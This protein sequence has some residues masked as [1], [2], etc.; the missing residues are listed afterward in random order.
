MHVLFR[1]KNH[2][3]DQSLKNRRLKRKKKDIRTQFSYKRKD[4]AFKGPSWRVTAFSVMHVNLSERTFCL[5]GISHF[6]PSSLLG[7]HGLGGP[8]ARHLVDK[9][10]SRASDA[11][12]RPTPLAPHRA[13][14]PQVYF[15]SKWLNG[16]IPMYGGMMLNKID[17]LDHLMCNPRWWTNTCQHSYSSSRIPVVKPR[18]Y[19]FVLLCRKKKTNSNYE[20]GHAYVQFYS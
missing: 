14:P 3:R 15:V 8:P 9:M 7:R 11:P 6:L 19:K 16:R 2:I 17:Q 20:S 12:S 18:S 1:K 10:P 5:L 4:T 13:L